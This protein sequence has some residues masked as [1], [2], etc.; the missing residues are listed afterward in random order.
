MK[1]H[2]IVKI[3]CMD[4]V[5]WPLVF[6]LILATLFYVAFGNI[7]EAEVSPVPVRCLCKRDYEMRVLPHSV[8]ALS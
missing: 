4:V 7:E 5:F 3:K 8:A 1:Y 2:L 6:P